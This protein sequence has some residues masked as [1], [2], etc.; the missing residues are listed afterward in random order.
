MLK[1]SKKIF[2]E[3]VN[4][5]FSEIY[6]CGK[7]DGS[8]GRHKYNQK[9]DGNLAG[10]HENIYKIRCFWYKLIFVEDR[11]KSTGIQIYITC[12]VLNCII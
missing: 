3:S 4:A 12:P 8:T 1:L 7:T 10:C 2:I 6:D 9:I 5:I 11:H